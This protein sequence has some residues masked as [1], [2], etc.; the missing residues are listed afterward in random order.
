MVNGLKAVNC[1]FQDEEFKK[2]LLLMIY[3]IITNFI[4]AV[5]DR[6]PRVY[7]WMSE[8]DGGIIAPWNI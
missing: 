7:P 2:H 3:G 4:H 6:T 8:P 5:K 1:D